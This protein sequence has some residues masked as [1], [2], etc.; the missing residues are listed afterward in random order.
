MIHTAREK[1]NALELVKLAELDDNMNIEF[2]EHFKFQQL[3]AEY[4]AGGLLTP[5]AAQVVY[6]AL[7]EVWSS[8]NG[9]WAADTD[10]ATKVIVTQLMQE[11]LTLS[12]RQ[13]LGRHLHPSR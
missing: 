4:H 5:E 9:G 6:L 10:T 11:L 8:K 7:G 1:C 3:Q 13:A 12:L 2:D